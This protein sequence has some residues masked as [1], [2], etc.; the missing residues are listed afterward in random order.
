MTGL[1]FDSNYCE[2]LLG[3]PDTTINFD[4]VSSLILFII[5][6]II[7][8]WTMTDRPM[9]GHCFF[10]FSLSIMEGGDAWCNLCQTK[11]KNFSKF[12]WNQVLEHCI[13]FESCNL[14]V[15][16]RSSAF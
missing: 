11:K 5:I 4:H 3:A 8:F 14:F 2:T 7:I 12:H 10:F 9:A 13:E 1:G 15:K 16:S 6:T